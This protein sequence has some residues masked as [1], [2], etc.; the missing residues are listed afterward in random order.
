MPSD[1]N[2]L[3]SAI[4]LA[5][6]LLAT[7]TA[8][9]EVAFGM[10]ERKAGRDPSTQEQDHVIR[11]FLLQAEETVRRTFLQIRASVVVG[12]YNTEDPSAAQVRR[13]TELHQL[14][15]LAPTLQ[16]I[17][18]RLLSLYPAISEALVEEARELFRQTEILIQ[19]ADRHQYPAEAESIAE[20]GMVFCTQLLQELDATRR[21]S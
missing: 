8:A 1:Y 20:R 2:A 12:Q 11:P 19:Q 14:R 18:Q 10:R 5:M 21:P 4:L 13:F 7:A 16:R 9:T 17:H 6:T 3:E 15:R